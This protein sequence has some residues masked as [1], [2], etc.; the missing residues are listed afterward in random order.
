M[1]KVK[2]LEEIILT[3]LRTEPTAI[4]I[5][6][7]PALL[8]VLRHDAETVYTYRINT[9]H[10]IGRDYRSTELFDQRAT[11]LYSSLAPYHED[12]IG[13]AR[14]ME[15][16]LLDDLSIAVVANMQVVIGKGTIV[17]EY[18]TVKTT[19]L[20]EVANEIEMDLPVLVKSIKEMCQD[21]RN[22]STPTYEL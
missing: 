8:Q 10:G 19:N 15:L 16:W 12:E 14:I 1:N 2:A 3:L 18:R 21:Y 9:C 11:Q 13:T 5:T 22:A 20:S 17:S 7:F 4:E 6:D